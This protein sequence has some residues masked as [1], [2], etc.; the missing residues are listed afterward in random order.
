MPDICVPCSAPGPRSPEAGSRPAWPRCLC[1]SLHTSDTSFPSRVQKCLWAGVC[2]RE[3]AWPENRSGA[4]RGP[5][6]TW[7]AGQCRVSPVRLGGTMLSSAPRNSCASRADGLREEVLAGGCSQGS[8]WRGP[9]RQTG[10]WP[11]APSLQ[12]TVAW[13]KKP[14][15]ATKGARAGLLGAD[16]QL[17]VS[18][19]QPGLLVPCWWGG[20]IRPGC[21][22]HTAHCPEHRLLSHLTPPCP[23]L[24]PPPARASQGPAHLSRFPVAPLFPPPSA[25][26][27]TRP[28]LSAAHAR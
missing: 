26:E 7:R 12:G 1:R 2:L 3:E 9:P 21:Q 5:P 18:A 28:P 16:G 4:R 14:K 11:P 23:S 27:N 22:P 24:R 8:F 17:G 13:A 15:W 19:C 20:W 25:L 6:P 10:P